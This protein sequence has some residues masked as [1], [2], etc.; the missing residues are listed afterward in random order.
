MS[1]LRSLQTSM[2]YYRGNKL[3]LSG[4]NVKLNLVGPISN[5]QSRKIYLFK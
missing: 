5:K 4:V 2:E 1:R 3:S